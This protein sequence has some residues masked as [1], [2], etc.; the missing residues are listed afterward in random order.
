MVIEM[1][2]TR[3]RELLHRVNLLCARGVLSAETRV[4]L[5][6]LLAQAHADGSQSMQ[7][8]GTAVTPR[9][10]KLHEVTVGAK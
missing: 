1:D 6:E 3:A 5:R 7:P 10:A 2:L 4:E 8:A 9:A